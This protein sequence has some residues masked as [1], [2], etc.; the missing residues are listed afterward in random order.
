[1]A[2]AYIFYGFD[3]AGSLAEETNNPRKHAP[4]AILRAMFAAFVLGA[5]LILFAIM[6]AQKNL[7]PGPRRRAARTS[8][9]RA[10]RRAWAT[11]SWSARRSRSP[12]ARWRCTRRASASCSRWRATAGC[13]S[14]SK[15]ARVSGRSQDADRPGARHRRADHRAAGAQH[16]QPAVFLV[17]T[18]VAI[19]LFYIA[20]LCVTGPMLIRRLRGEWPRPGPRPVL[21]A[22]AS[23]GSSST[24]S[25]SSTR[26]WSS[27]TWPGRGRTSTAQPGWYLQYGA[28]VFVGH[29]RD[30]RR[31]VL[32]RRATTGG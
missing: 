5:L 18:S 20:Y 15:I 30:R 26:R 16:R 13:R 31:R 19:I 9:R 28:F 23:S 17:L 21:L 14:G 7:A 27:S 6:A 12:C 29:R 1:M 22:R 11:C 10:G 32:L 25:P 4:S 24:W 3:T 2:S 8:S